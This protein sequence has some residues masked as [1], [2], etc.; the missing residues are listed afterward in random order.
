M[1]SS[2]VSRSNGRAVVV[3]S[4]RTISPPYSRAAPKSTRN[5][6]GSSEGSLRQ[7][8][9]TQRS[10]AHR[11]SC[12]GSALDAWTAGVE[13]KL[14]SSRHRLAI[15]TVPFPPGGAA[16]ASSIAPTWRMGPL[17]AGPHA[18][19]I[20]LLLIRRDRHSAGKPKPSSW[21]RQTLWPLGSTSLSSSLLAGATPW[22][23]KVKAYASGSGNE[24]RLRA[25]TKPAP[26]LKSKSS[27]RA[28]PRG[29]RSREMSSCACPDAT[30]VQPEMSVKS[31]RISPFIVVGAVI[32]PRTARRRGRRQ[33]PPSR[34]GG[35][36]TESVRCSRGPCVRWGPGVGQ[37]RA[38]DN[39]LL[40]AYFVD[41]Y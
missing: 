16:I 28:P 7:L 38:E 41:R 3:G 36:R 34:A 40:L 2:E 31:S 20:W 22:T 24:K 10:T 35:S 30:G 23:S 29:P 4:H 19:S 33:L 8:V 14:W 32:R 5:H 25:T 15:Q 9:S 17:P 39:R 26:P 12:P 13:R 18:K 27:R 21:Y 11:G 37:E 6:C 1:P